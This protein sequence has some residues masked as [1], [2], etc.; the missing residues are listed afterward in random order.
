MKKF[1]VL[2]K[3]KEF[4]RN[5]RHLKFPSY[6]KSQFF[7]AALSI[8]LNLSGGNT[9]FSMKDKARFF[10]IA[11]GSARECKTAL[12]LHGLENIKIYRDSD[13]LCAILYK[14]IKSIY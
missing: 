4:Y 8:S 10:K 1:F 11:F 9:R 6:V 3:S 7:R 13:F 14:L 5:A 12:G 2:E